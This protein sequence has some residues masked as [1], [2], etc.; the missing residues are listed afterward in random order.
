MAWARPEKPA[1]RREC[2]DWFE[3]HAAG[4]V[5]ISAAEGTFSES[6][7]RALAAHALTHKA[8]PDGVKEHVIRERDGGGA[9]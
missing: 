6:E 5:K 3:K 8:M 4:N 1:D 2:K 7:R 9:A